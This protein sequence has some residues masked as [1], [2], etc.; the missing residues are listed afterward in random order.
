MPYK[1]RRMSAAEREAIVRRRRD[2]GWPLHAPP[3][4]FRHAGTY[5]LTAATF[6]HVPIMAGAARL[7]EVSGLLLRSLRE[8]GTEVFAWVVLPNHYHVLAGVRALADVS[9]ALGRLHG[10]TSRAWNLADGLTGRRVWY[11]FADR[12][13]RND[14]HFLRAITYIHGNAVKHGYT[15]TPES[16]WW[17][18]LHEYLVANRQEWLERIGARYPADGFGRGWDDG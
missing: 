2:Q 5:I 18:S 9:A 13:I 10:S 14:A 3:H 15:A 12:L 4:P 6:E 8:I 11:R 16:W 17:S 7:T 1:Y